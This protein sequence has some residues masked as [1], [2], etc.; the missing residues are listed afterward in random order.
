MAIIVVNLNRIITE[1]FIEEAVAEAK[2]SSGDYDDDAGIEAFR[3]MLSENLGKTM[4]EYQEMMAVFSL[5]QW[6]GN[7][8]SMIRNKMR[9]K[10]VVAQ[11]SHKTINS[12]FREEIADSWL[13]REDENPGIITKELE[14]IEKDLQKFR[15]G[16]Q[17]LR[18]YKEKRDIIMFAINALL[19][20][21]RV[22]SV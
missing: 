3:Y 13:K 22:K 16:G 21:G 15:H 4:L 20:N 2:K 5:L 19:L 17:E 8:Q 14:S 10:D 7:L 18:F 11:F 1:K 12:T 6:N 9:R